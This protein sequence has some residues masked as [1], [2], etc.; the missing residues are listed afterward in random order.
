MPKSVCFYVH[1]V[2]KTRRWINLQA[3]AGH[4]SS[5]SYI[6]VFVAVFRKL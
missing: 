6:R 5:R 3:V 2:S 1:K 4:E